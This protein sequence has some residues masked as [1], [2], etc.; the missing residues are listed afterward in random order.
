MFFR[1][2]A[3]TGRKSVAKRG[4]V[5][6][7]SK[8]DADC[9]RKTTLVGV[10]LIHVVARRSNAF[11]PKDRE[12]AGCP[13]K[14]FTK[15]SSPLLSD[16]CV[17]CQMGTRPGEGEICIQGPEFDPCTEEVDVSLVMTL[18]GGR[19]LGARCTC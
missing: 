16:K 6:P 18:D 17:R 4:P 2:L 19:S 1:L 13:W 3:M 12:R 9:C 10:G 8:A 11:A 15:S 14:G 7:I 5:T